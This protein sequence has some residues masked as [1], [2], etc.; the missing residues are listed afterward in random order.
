M[1]ALQDEAELDVPILPEVLRDAQVAID[2]DYATVAYGV[3]PAGEIDFADSSRIRPWPANPSVSCLMVTR[4]VIDI[5]RHAVACYAAQS[6]PVREL[7]VVTDADRAGAVEDFLSRQSLARYTVTGAPPGLSL[8]DLRNMAMARSRGHILM[9]WDDDD[10]YDPHR[11]RSAVTVLKATDAAAVFLE[12]W[13]IWWPARGLAALSA[14]R[15]WE[16]SV[17]AR[18]EHARPFPA[19]SRDEDTYPNQAIAQGH[20][21][22]LVQ[23]PLQYV[24][25]ITG[26]NTWDE[27]H[28]EAMLRQSPH[29]FRG[30]DY[31]ALLEVLDRR[32]PI[33]AYAASLLG[34]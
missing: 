5:L 13:L 9:Q 30:A 34:G 17:A 10:L 11:I 31:E 1:S 32:M 3:A 15:T 6:W 27:P 18:R 7:V 24:Y 28:F 29:V 2:S 21:I 23:A 22:G 14:P 8:G 26:R 20:A 25:T 16:G 4:G 19:L 33:R 12:Q